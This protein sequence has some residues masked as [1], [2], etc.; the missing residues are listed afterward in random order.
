MFLADAVAGYLEDLTADNGG[1]AG[2]REVDSFCASDPAGPSSD[3]A[4]VVFLRDV[5]RGSAE[6]REYFVEYF[7]LQ[8]RLVSCPFTG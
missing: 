7:S 3:P 1:L 6:Q 8:G 2:V 5:V 4:P